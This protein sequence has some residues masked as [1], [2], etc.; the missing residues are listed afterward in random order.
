[1]KYQFGNRLEDYNIY[2]H[3]IVI[4]L[5]SK[6]I[7]LII[8]NHFYIEFLDYP[9]IEIVIQDLLLAQ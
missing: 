2:Y 6:L 9:E 8:S 3:L 4:I 7:H 5:F 1:M